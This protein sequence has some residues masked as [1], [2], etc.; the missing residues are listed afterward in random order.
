MIT[1][2]IYVPL[3]HDV[4]PYIIL[5]PGFDFTMSQQSLATAVNNLTRRIIG[6]TALKTVDLSDVLVDAFQTLGAEMQAS[7]DA[8]ISF[9]LP[10]LSVTVIVR[11]KTCQRAANTGQWARA[12]D[13]CL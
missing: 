8:L 4:K 3:G 6:F 1:L 7:H 13:F 9:A 2:V 11:R 10:H 5:N 12:R